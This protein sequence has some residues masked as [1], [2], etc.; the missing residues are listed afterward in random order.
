MTLPKNSS[1]MPRQSVISTA[2]KSRL[3]AEVFASLDWTFSPDTILSCQTLIQDQDR[4]QGQRPAGAFLSPGTSQ[5]TGHLLAVALGKPLHCSGLL[6][7]IHPSKLN[8]ES[9][10]IFYDFKQFGEIRDTSPLFRWPWNRKG[11]SYGW[12]ICQTK[13]TLAG[14]RRRSMYCI[15]LAGP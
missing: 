9:C 12:L 1:L 4:F 14:N 15:D 3:S 6:M 8:S 5:P 10:W 7:L 2:S 13:Q 11:W